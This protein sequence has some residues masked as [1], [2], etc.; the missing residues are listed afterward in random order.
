NT[1]VQPEYDS[2]RPAG[3][4]NHIARMTVPDMPMQGDADLAETVRKIDASLE[5]AL[6]QLMTCRPDALVLGIS[7]ESIWGGG[8]EPSRKIADR[9]RR[10]AGD[11]KLAQASDALP[12]ALRALKVERRIGL[13]SPYH[14]VAFPYLEQFWA[15]V[16]FEQVR[17]VSLPA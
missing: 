10:I 4:T 17:S 14:P 11:L 5:P 2:M 9:V 12:A 3:V 13:L 15:E 8:L 6:E 16:G 1:V 7:A